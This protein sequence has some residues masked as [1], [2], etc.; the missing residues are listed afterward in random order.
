M[1]DLLSYL[2]EVEP[3]IVVASL[4][5]TAGVFIYTLVTIEEISPF[6]RAVIVSN[7]LARLF[8]IPLPVAATLIAL[9]YACVPCQQWLALFSFG[10]IVLD[11]LVI[12]AFCI[13]V[14]PQLDKKK[15]PW[16][17]EYLLPRFEEAQSTDVEEIKKPD[18]E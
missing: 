6:P 4:I 14:V 17:I 2:A 11:L 3:L 5:V 13:I 12:L 16:S 18:G 15:K 10:L 9:V 8:C 7:K 1:K